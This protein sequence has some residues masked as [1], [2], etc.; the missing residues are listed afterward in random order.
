M[1]KSLLDKLTKAHSAVY[2]SVPGPTS[3]ISLFG[4]DVKDLFFFVTAN[5]ES[6]LLFNVLTYN[7]R[8]TFAGMADNATGIDCKVLIQEF[9]KLLQ[10]NL[11]YIK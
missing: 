6:A 8:F 9:E 2:T 11:G 7:E 3:A 4:H 1:Q 10:E 5:S